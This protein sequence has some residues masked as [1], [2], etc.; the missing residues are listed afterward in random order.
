MAGSQPARRAPCPRHDANCDSAICPAGLAHRYGAD[1]FVRAGNCAAG[2][3]NGAP[4][5]RP[6]NAARDHSGSRAL[7]QACAPFFV[8]RNG[9]LA[10]V[11]RANKR[12]GSERCDPQDP[13]ARV[14]R[15]H[16]KTPTATRDSQSK[17]ANQEFSDGSH[18]QKRTAS[19]PSLPFSYPAEPYRPV[20]CARELPPPI[21]SASSR[22]F[23]SF[24]ATA[25][26]RRRGV[27]SRG[28]NA[29]SCVSVH[30]RSPAANGT[31]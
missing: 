20:N 21:R 14:N 12:A 1:S 11:S 30:F 23:G 2:R 4:A 10:I 22:Y 9:L 18:L 7:S 26:R 24:H 19:E 6:Q 5:Y 28:S 16:I 31:R 13:P 25:A 17:N 3:K 8:A 29:L 15:F 27:S